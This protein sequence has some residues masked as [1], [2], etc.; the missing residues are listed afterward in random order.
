M[1]DEQM[2]DQMAGQAANGVPVGAFNVQELQQT[3]IAMQNEIF[4]LQAAAR[5]V[6]QGIDAHVQHV[7]QEEMHRA[8]GRPAPALGKARA[9]PPEE[10][11]GD[12][13]DLPLN[14]WLAQL[15]TYFDCTGTEHPRQQVLVAAGCL[16]GAA[17]TWWRSRY[18]ESTRGDRDLPFSVHQLVADLRQQFGLIFQNRDFRREW[19]RLRQGGKDVAEYTHR[20]KQIAMQIEDTNDGEKLH[21]YIEGLNSRLKV[22]VETERPR[23]LDRAI[24]LAAVWEGPLDL[25]DERY[26]R[27]PN[28]ERGRG[29]NLSR[30]RSQSRGRSYSRGRSQ[31]GERENDRSYRREYPDYSRTR[32]QGEPMELGN[33]STRVRYDRSYSPDR[34]RPQ[35]PIRRRP[36]GA[37]I[38][39]GR[40]ERDSLRA[41]RFRPGG[42]EIAP[43]RRERD[44]SRAARSRRDVGRR[45]EDREC[46]RCG[47]V[48]HLAADCQGN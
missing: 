16:R 18:E 47:Q 33:R 12:P 48:G 32:P 31:S 26:R 39:P 6:E 11:Y 21:R 17:G 28:R 1:A 4:N 27:S 23:T 8:D 36:G 46:Y 42:A 10:W 30:G 19:A 24:E 13:K 22:R 43:E 37:E 5:G 2:A 44:S 29:R 20:F 25:R 35:T 38:A 9:N 41:V 15:Q 14:D 7:V 34:G 45:S 40:R 3:I